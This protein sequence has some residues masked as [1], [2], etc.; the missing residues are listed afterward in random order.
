VAAIVRHAAVGFERRNKRLP[1]AGARRYITS[2]IEQLHLYVS[3][4]RSAGVCRS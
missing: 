4:R 1:S 3:V 2:F